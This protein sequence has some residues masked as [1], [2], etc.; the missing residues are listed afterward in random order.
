MVDAAIVPI[1]KQHNTREENRQIK[2][3]D[4]PEACGDNKRRQKNVAARWTMKHG[5]THC[6]YKSRIGIDRK[7][8]VIR[9]YA[10][11]SAEV[12]GSKVFE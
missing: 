10:V 9:K 2:V 4:S 8:K 1:P 5:K 12:H 6:G 3:G 11:T 7:H